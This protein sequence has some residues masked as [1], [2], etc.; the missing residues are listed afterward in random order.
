MAAT[1]L[2]KIEMF[3]GLRV[4]LV[5]LVDL[6]DVLLERVP[7]LTLLVTSRKSVFICGNP[8]IAA[9]VPSIL[10]QILQTDYQA[11]QCSDL[12]DR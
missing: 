6:A 12:A 5:P 9:F 4:H 8:W 7:T 11:A 3:G 2:C 10:K 1:P